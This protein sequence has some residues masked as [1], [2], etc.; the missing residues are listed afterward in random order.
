MV[1]NIL[2]P[3]ARALAGALRQA[4]ESAGVSLRS[5]AKKLEISPSVVSYW[6]T[7]KRTP[8]LDEV[9][10]YLYA[11]GVPRQQ[12]KAILDLA[13]P[14]PAPDWLTIGHPGAAQ[15]L[16]GVVEC[17][18]EAVSIT[19]WSIGLIPGLLQTADYARAI[20][21]PDS[22]A[23]VQARLS[24]QK[25]LSGHRPVRFTALICELA[26]RQVIGGREVMADQLRYLLHAT[27]LETVVFRVMPIGE[28][29]HPGLMGPFIL[30]NF[31]AAPTIVHVEHHR[32]GAFLF[33]NDDV[34]AY[35]D[36]A[37]KI[38]EGAM[39]PELSFGL[40]AE[41]LNGMETVT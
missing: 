10:N 34:R 37:A 40:T 22:E 2:G 21:G 3:R 28:G 27:A 32:N 41:I 7:G 19:E 6:E 11:L 35:K 12:R 1:A 30:Y 13:R 25:V 5:V 36:A 38:L 8:S 16:A 39:D 26:L 23:G 31:A 29:W 17:E 15:Q 33:E 20:F 9:A 18:R 14:L 4:R 24:R